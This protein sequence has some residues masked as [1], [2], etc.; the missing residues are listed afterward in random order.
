MTSENPTWV[1]RAENA[2][3]EESV[4]NGVVSAEPGTNQ[5]GTPTPTLHENHGHHDDA[6]SKKE[7]LDGDVEAQ[8]SAEESS[9]MSGPKLYLVFVSLMFCIFMFALDQS[10]VATAIPVIVSDF[11]A[12]DKVGWV[13]TGYFLTQCGLILLAG[14]LLTVVRAKWTLL[15]SIFWFELGSLIC[16]VSHSMSVLIF[17]RAVQGI[18]SCPSWPSLL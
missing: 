9:V 5:S 1:E 7:G 17:A 4:Q 10:I 3:A 14:Q 13:I 6:L 18:G 2:M 12:F 11:H 8:H 16:A 15:G